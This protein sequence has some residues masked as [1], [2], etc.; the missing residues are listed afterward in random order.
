MLGYHGCEAG[1]GERLLNGEAF[2]ASENDYD[3][4]GPGAYFWEANPV[5][6]YEFAG[7]AS[8]RK[9]WID[10]PFVVG[11]VVDLGNC[12]DLTTSSGLAPVKAA[13]ESL[14]KVQALSGRPILENRQDLRTRKLD[15]AVI[16]RVHEI[17]EELRMPSIDTVKGIFVE[18]EELYPGAGFREK[19][20]TQIAVCDPACVK[21]IFRVAR[22]EYAGG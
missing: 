11:A 20:H 6:A 22:S 7:E 5:R 15:C 21:G 10:A 2:R 8:K 13:Y 14:V 18:G 1:T 9:A 19:T 3:W 12:L 17:V 4:L 16:R